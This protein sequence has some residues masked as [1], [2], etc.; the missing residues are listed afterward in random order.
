MQTSNIEHRFS[1]PRS[2]WP[3][4]PPHFTFIHRVS[5]CHDGNLHSH[6]RR[7]FI[8]PPPYLLLHPGQIPDGEISRKNIRSWN[9]LAHVHPIVASYGPRNLFVISTRGYLRKI[10]RL[11]NRP[12]L[13]RPIADS[14]YRHHQNALSPRPDGTCRCTDRA[15]HR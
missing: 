5:T 7:R 1:R 8:F 14:R 4:L 9:I 2:L 12:I 10:Y 11:R 13:Q 15:L 3:L 6:R